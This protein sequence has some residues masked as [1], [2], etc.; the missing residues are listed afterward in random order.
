MKCFKEHRLLS[1]ITMAMICLMLTGSYS[2]TRLQSFE[3]IRTAVATNDPVLDGT[4]AGKTYQFADMPA[5]A[6]KMS[7]TDNNV[8]IY[9]YGTDAAAETCNFKIYAYREGGPAIPVFSGVVTLGTALQ[10]TGTY[11]G[12]TITGT[13]TWPTDVL[14]TNSGNNGLCSIWLDLN[15]CK[16]VSIEKDIPAS[17]QVATISDKIAGF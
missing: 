6:K 11:Y 4:T 16:Y 10:A 9:F 8:Q 17:A 3:K 1:F 12:G 14:I 13:D 5:T 7:N 2:E 15:G